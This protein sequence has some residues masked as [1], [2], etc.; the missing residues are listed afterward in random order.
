MRL[1]LSFL[2]ALL[3]SACASLEFQR[4]HFFSVQWEADGASKNVRFCDL[5]A[6]GQKIGLDPE[7]AVGLRHIRS[8]RVTRDEG[9]ATYS[10]ILT[11]T[12]EGQTRLK[13]LS[14]KNIRRRLAIVLDDEVVGLPT[15]MRPLDGSELPLMP[16][17]DESLA[18]VLAQ[19]INN[20]IDAS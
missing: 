16:T 8:A 10:V 2:A 19:R 20:A 6:T 4:Q 7:I 18:K 17:G 3:L 9:T 15:V 5:K 13:D 14:S 11:L 12:P 1:K